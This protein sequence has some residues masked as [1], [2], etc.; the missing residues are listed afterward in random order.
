[1]ITKQGNK[2]DKNTTILFFTGSIANQ[3]ANLISL[4]F[5]ILKGTYLWYFHFGWFASYTWLGY[6]ALLSALGGLGSLGAAAA[7]ARCAWLPWLGAAARGAA[8]RGSRDGSAALLAGRQHLTLARSTSPGYYALPHHMVLISRIF[9]CL[10]HFFHCN[11]W[12]YQHN[13]VIPYLW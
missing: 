12:V 5:T 10:I 4:T 3:Y 7:A 8:A 2:Q 9:H 6:V 13:L 1:M 11:C